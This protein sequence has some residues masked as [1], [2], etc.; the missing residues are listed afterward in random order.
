MKIVSLA[1]YLG[2]VRRVKKRDMKSSSSAAVNIFFRQAVI[3][4]MLAMTT[5]AVIQA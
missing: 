3:F 2:L 1:R 5:M 4:V